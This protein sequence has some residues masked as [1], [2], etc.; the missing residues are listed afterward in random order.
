MQE[1]IQKNLCTIQLFTKESRE[2]KN[3]DEGGEIFDLL[4]KAQ[5]RD[6][7]HNS[8]LNIPS[9]SCDLQPTE[10]CNMETVLVPR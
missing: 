2:G 1:N 8:V 10:D 9:E 5:C 4:L 6:E 3:R 7:D